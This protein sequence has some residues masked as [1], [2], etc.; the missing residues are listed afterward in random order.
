MAVPMARSGVKSLTG[1]GVGRR[2]RLNAG[3]GLVGF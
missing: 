1:V 3:R 2:M